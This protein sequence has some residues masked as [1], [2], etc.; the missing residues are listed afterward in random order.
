MLAHEK[1]D[2][3]FEFERAR[4]VVFDQICRQSDQKHN[5]FHSDG[6]VADRLETRQPQGAR[7]GVDCVNAVDCQMPLCN[8]TG[9][10][11]PDTFVLVLAKEGACEGAI[12]ASPRSA[13]WW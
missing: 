4:A 7:T 10:G 11:F 6:E 9:R 1:G 2:L 12:W 13:A 8:L 5:P 3:L